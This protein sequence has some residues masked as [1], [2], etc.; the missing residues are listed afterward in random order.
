MNILKIFTEKRII[1]NIGEDAVCKYL[2]K[3]GYRILQK[4]YVQDG[5]EIDIIAENKEYIC[6]TEVKTRTL[7]H[8]NPKELRPASA[9]TKKKQKSLISAARFFAAMN[10][11]KSKKFR[12]DVAEVFITENKQINKINYMENA[13]SLNTAYAK[14]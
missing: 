7:G 4:N 14:R 1:G 3:Q 12:F 13:F 8:E 10:S 6:F 2:K 5:H 9:V 11:D